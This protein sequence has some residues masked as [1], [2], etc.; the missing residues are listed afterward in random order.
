MGHRRFELSAGLH[1]L[2]G[3]RCETFSRL[4]SVQ[5]TGLQSLLCRCDDA[6]KR[7][8]PLALIRASFER[9][10]RRAPG[11]LSTGI[12]PDVFS[13]YSAQ[14]R[15]RREALQII[16]LV[17]AL[18]IVLREVGLTANNNFSRF[19]FAFAFLFPPLH[20][21]LHWGQPTPLLLLLLVASWASARRG[22]T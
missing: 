11:G 6:S 1:W 15:T 8:Q 14:T 21:A 22:W 5:A 19:A 16:A 10:P 7:R 12:L 18:I 17:S 20:S 2:F 13:I 4:R 3:D 9:E